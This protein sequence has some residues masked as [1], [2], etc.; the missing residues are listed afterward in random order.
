MELVNK[1]STADTTGEGASITTADI[2]QDGWLDVV[3]GLGAS[4]LRKPDTVHIFFGGQDGYDPKRKQIYYGGYSAGYNG[5]ADYNNDGNLDIMTSAYSSATT[6]V[7]PAQLFFGDGKTIDFEKPLNLFSEGSTAVMQMDFNRDGW[8]DA[9]VLCHRNDVTHQVPSRLYWNSP[10][11]FSEDK[12]T[13]LPGLGPHGTT[14][15]EFGNA[16]TRA[17]WEEY[18]SPAYDTAGRKAT[19]LSWLADTPADTALRFQ[20][21]AANT[22]EELENA[23]WIGPEGA[24]SF[25]DK[26]GTQVSGLPKGAG[27]LQYKARFVYPTGCRSPRLRQVR[28]DFAPGALSR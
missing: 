21:R 3:L 5:I 19:S 16:Y 23:P 17:P 1:A 7:L 8:L 25:Y 15:R 20:L 12:V 13:L 4:R 28:V 10:Q 6:R 18:V 9:F 26:P 11:G 22:A 24:G 2:N 14:A 27:S